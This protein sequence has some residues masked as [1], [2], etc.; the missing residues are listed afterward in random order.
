[1]FLS[2]KDLL[3]NTLQEQSSFQNQGIKLWGN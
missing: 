1:M 2:E 3:S